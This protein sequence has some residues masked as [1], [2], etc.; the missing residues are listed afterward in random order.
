MKKL[1]TVTAALLITSIGATCH[2]ASSCDIFKE[3]LTN[4]ERRAGFIVSR[5]TYEDKSPYGDG[6]TSW[7]IP[8]L[9]GFT[10]EIQC[11]DNGAFHL[12]NLDNDGSDVVSGR[13][14]N[15]VGAVI[16]AYTGWSHE[17]IVKLAAQLFA[18]V[19]ADY[20]KSRVRGDDQEQGHIR[21]NFSDGSYV[22]MWAAK[23]EFSMSLNEKD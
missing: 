19:V 15:V 3:R 8:N 12:F 23:E 14:L 6:N 21:F 13:I 22:D 1:V 16:Y 9:K 11:H 5:A 17:K 20:K 4:A 18:D 2:A 10:A 7:R